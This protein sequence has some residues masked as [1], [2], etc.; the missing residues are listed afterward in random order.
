MYYR[1]CLVL[2]TESQN[3]GTENFSE[4]ALIQL[5]HFIDENIEARESKLFP[6]G[7]TELGTGLRTPA[8]QVEL[9][10]SFPS[11]R[12]SPQIWPHSALGGKALPVYPGETG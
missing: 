11:G 12:N 2:P 9:P 4:T 10:F 6:Q 7:L 5:S 3:S 1:S 8:F